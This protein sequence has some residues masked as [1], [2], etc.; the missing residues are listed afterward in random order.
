MPAPPANR[1]VVGVGGA[2]TLI[3]AGES[4]ECQASFDQP[5]RTKR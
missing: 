3:P 4:H 5:Q 2:R 1:V